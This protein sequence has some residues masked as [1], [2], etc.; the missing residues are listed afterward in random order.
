MNVRRW[1]G[2]GGHSGDRRGRGTHDGYG[3]PGRQASEPSV[4]KAGRTA[5]AEANLKLT[6]MNLRADATIEPESSWHLDRGMIDQFGE[7]ASMAPQD[8]ESPRSTPGG[9][10]YRTT[11]ERMRLALRSAEAEPSGHSTRYEAGP[12]HREQRRR[13]THSADCR[14][15]R[16]AIAMRAVA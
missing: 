13:G 10:P 2:R 12:G 15:R 4:R 5:C 1:A 11:V 7:E 14:D 9:N 8:L 16:S 6:E 3:R